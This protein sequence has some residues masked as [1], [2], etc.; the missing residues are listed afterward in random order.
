MR[1]VKFAAVAGMVGLLACGGGGGS[2]GPTGPGNPGPGPGPGNPPAGTILIQAASFNPSSTTVV[3]GGTITFTNNN[4]G[5]HNVIWSSNPP[6]E[7]NIDD[8][9][10]GSNV[11][12]FPNLG[13]S[14][15]TCTLHGFSGTIQVQ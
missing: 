4:T 2:G 15:F 7:G 8:H 12:T 1:S 13:Q 9:A 6:S 14:N 3:R 11:R 5:V 10:S